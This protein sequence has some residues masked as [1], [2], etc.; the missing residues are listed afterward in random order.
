M[1]NK[2]TYRGYM[3]RRSNCGGFIFLYLANGTIRTVSAKTMP[4]CMQLI[5]QCIKERVNNEFSK[6]A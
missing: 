5:D 2:F 3:I 4:E 1:K 6:V